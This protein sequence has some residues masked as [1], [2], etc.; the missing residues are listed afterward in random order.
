MEYVLIL[1]DKPFDNRVIET[2][3]VKVQVITKGQIMIGLR[4]KYIRPTLVIDEIQDRTWLN[5]KGE[6]IFE[7]WWNE[8]VL[9]CACKAK[10][11][12]A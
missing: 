7:Q 2:E 3:K 11:I 6:D 12:K 9:P 10:I 5:S 4:F 8:C 1:V